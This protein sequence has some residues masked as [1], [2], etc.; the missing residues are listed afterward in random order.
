MKMTRLLLALLILVSCSTPDQIWIR[1]DSNYRV[2]PIDNYYFKTNGNRFKMGKISTEEEKRIRLDTLPEDISYLLRLLSSSQDS[3]CVLTNDL[4]KIEKVEKPDDDIYPD[5]VYRKSTQIKIDTLGL[6]SFLLEKKWLYDTED[7]EYEK[8]TL[9]FSSR[10]KGEFYLFNFANSQRTGCWNIYQIEEGLVFLF[11]YYDDFFTARYS[12][13]KNQIVQFDKNRI[14][15]VRY[16]GDRTEQKIIKRLE[17][18]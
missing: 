11:L 5:M 18:E 3:M 13:F 12:L 7:P 9:E 8:D 6:R 15:A 4:K 17:E 2:S 14:E 1:A 16:I 10:K